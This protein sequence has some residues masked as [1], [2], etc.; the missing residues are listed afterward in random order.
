MTDTE[1]LIKKLKH[2][3]AVVKEANAS[4]QSLLDLRAGSDE[5]SQVKM[6]SG[7]LAKSIIK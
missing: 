1:L 7:E 4:V 5:A 3:I 6:S 2:C